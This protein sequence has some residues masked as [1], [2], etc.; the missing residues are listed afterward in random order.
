[1]GFEIEKGFQEA[2]FAFNARSNYVFSI[3]DSDDVNISAAR[4]ISNFS[5]SFILEENSSKRFQL[6]NISLVIS[7]EHV[8]DK[9]DSMNN[10]FDYLKNNN[11]LNINS[12]FR[13]EFLGKV[14]GEQIIGYYSNGKSYKNPFINDFI[15][16]QTISD[17]ASS[18]PIFQGAKIIFEFG[19][20]NL[21]KDIFSFFRDSIFFKVFS[22]SYKDK[23][24]NVYIVGS[25]IYVP[26]NVGDVY[27]NGFD[28]E[29][30]IQSKSK[31][32]FLKTYFSNYK[33]SDNRAFQFQPDWIFK[34]KLSFP[35][36]KYN[37]GL[38]HRL[39]SGIQLTTMK[40]S[41]VFYYDQLQV[42]NSV[43]CFISRLIEYKYFNYVIELSFRNILNNTVYIDQF[44]IYE[45]KYLL[46]FKLDLF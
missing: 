41:G 14:F 28:F 15:I 34:N 23:I 36:K 32:Y 30:K 8:K 20:K 27:I 37:V 24:K 3:W 46:S 2:V 26:I 44:P 33:K 31:L 22:I 18:L 12:S 39:E 6:K 42:N 17:L 43:D 19:F 11:W 7:R 35:F 1:M 29:S 13:I 16:N 21:N 5:G 4:S 40:R 25:P 38:I 9:P 45:T 10:S